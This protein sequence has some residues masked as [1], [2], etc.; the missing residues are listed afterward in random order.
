MPIRR[1]PR[2]VG[3]QYA[4]ALERL[5]GDKS[6]AELEDRIRNPDA[7]DPLAKSVRAALEQDGVDPAQAQAETMRSVMAIALARLGRELGQRPTRS[8]A[9]TIDLRTVSKEVSKAVADLLRAVSQVEHIPGALDEHGLVPL[10]K[11]VAAEAGH[12]F[13]D[14]GAKATPELVVKEMKRL[15]KSFDE[16]TLAK[17][18]ESF[19]SQMPTPEEL[20]D[21]KAAARK[22]H[23]AGIVK[24]VI[25]HN[26]GSS[27]YVVVQLVRERGELDFTARALRGLYRAFPDVL[28]LALASR[29]QAD[30]IAVRPAGP[31]GDYH[32]LDT[33]DP[34]CRILVARACED[35]A[36]LDGVN[37]IAERLGD[38]PLW[39]RRFGAAP[40]DHALRAYLKDV[41]PDRYGAW[42]DVQAQKVT[43]ALVQALAEAPEGASLYGVVR[44]LKSEHG[45]FSTQRWIEGKLVKRWEKEPELFPEAQALKVR[46]KGFVLEGR[47]EKPEPAPPKPKP[48]VYD[49]AFARMIA[50]LYDAE[51]GALRAH[52]VGVVRQ[53]DPAFTGR[54]LRMLAAEFPDVGVGLSF[55][56]LGDREHLAQAYGVVRGMY[57]LATVWELSAIALEQGLPRLGE[58]QLKKLAKAHPDLFSLDGIHEPGA[59]SVAPASAVSNVEGMTDKSETLIEGYVRDAKPGDTLKVVHQRLNDDPYLSR[60]HGKLHRE[61][62]R[63][64]IK[65]RV[66]EAADWKVY[67]VVKVATVLHEYIQNN[68]DVP[69]LSRLVKRIKA[70]YPGFPSYVTLC[71]STQATFEKHLDRMPWLREYRT[72]PGKFKFGS[73][74]RSD[75]MQLTAELRDILAKA[76]ADAPE[77]WTNEDIYRDLNDNHPVIQKKYPGVSE[78]TV[79][80]I[81]A[82]FGRDVVP[83][84]VGQAQP[85]K[86]TVDRR[87]ADEIREDAQRLARDLTKIIK[88]GGKPKLNAIAEEWDVDPQYFKRLMGKHPRLFPHWKKRYPM[89]EH[90]AKIIG[91]VTET[92]PI[93]AT[94]RDL[95]AAVHASGLLPPDMKFT[96]R[97]V[98]NYERKF[99]GLIPNLKEQNEARFLRVLGREVW[100]APKDESVRQVVLRVGERFGET[101][102]SW[103]RLK[104]E[105]IPAWNAALDNGEPVPPWVKRVAGRSKTFPEDGLAKDA[106]KLPPEENTEID[107]ELAQ[108]GEIPQRLEMLERIV[109]RRAK[110]AFSDFNVLHIQHLLGSNYKFIDAVHRLGCPKEDMLT[111]GI[112]YSTSETVADVMEGEGYEVM[113]P[114]LNIAAWERQVEDAVYQMVEK[115]KANGKEVVVFDDGGLVAKILHERPWAK[116]Y[117]KLFRVVE[118]TTRGIT[119]ASKYDL[120]VP[121]VNYAQDP[122]KD[123]EGPMI[124]EVVLD[125]MR[126]RF[127]GIGMGDVTGKK[128]TVNGFGVIGAATAVELAKAGAEVTVYDPDAGARK[129][130]KAMAKKL[131]L[132]IKVLA[133]PEEAFAGA[134]MIV[135]CTGHESITRA[136]I[137]AAADGCVLVSTSS[138]LVEID[139]GY[140]DERASSEDGLARE[141]LRDG[142]HPPSCR[143]TFD[144]G[145]EIVVLADGFPVNFDGK[146]NCVEPDEIQLTHAGMLI[147]G[148]QATWKDLEPGLNDL[149]DDLREE[150][151]SDWKDVR[152]K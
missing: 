8:T 79:T 118:Q 30:E 136:A 148:F 105:L 63:E 37:H 106:A 82:K 98:K 149:D 129:R 91:Y 5:D 56:D 12:V 66:P 32:V 123:L 24:D 132:D 3:P 151:I 20:A 64:V 4:H 122:A 1:V 16:E 113:K 2:L 119:V 26:P 88:A 7:R 97:S 76:F 22:Q 108:L 41:F 114:P 11:E 143:Y 109:A 142:E 135:G 25:D 121:I 128:L 107:R 67:N 102:V 14:L 70:D 87:T 81:R 48:G 140:I 61:Q 126:E 80:G 40:G 59:L 99:P 60:H 127:A 117:R 78:S 69:S 131:K 17:L 84:R 152:G 93:G 54:R 53:F 46:G 51:P 42:T 130:A 141:Q 77:A 147:A 86:D 104:D 150:L 34:I 9:E 58:A 57:P 89:T 95:E 31:A 116:P 18:Q 133:K 74:A 110:N 27:H 47:G 103:E 35:A 6:F 52:I 19:P 124:G 92:L 33:T 13:D 146:V 44:E 21:L 15:Y 72:S 139:M 90:R 39:K 138:K 75:N 115:A 68:P 28:E 71:G 101:I 73:H 125:R 144:D 85:R 111:V 134:E 120:D 45:T 43:R 38:N 96:W 83:R 29:D 100:T 55:H 112:P 36:P 62:V 137:D 49:E 94:L 50:E 65:A 10:K 23:L 145:K